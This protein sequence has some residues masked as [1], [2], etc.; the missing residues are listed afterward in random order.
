MKTKRHLKILE[1]VR[2]Y[3]VETQDALAEL[4]IEE[5]YEVTQ[6]TISRDIKQLRL[7]KSAT[8]D[9]KYVYAVS[10][11]DDTETSTGKAL[12]ILR[13]TIKKIDVAQNILVVKTYSGMAQAAAAALDSLNYK[14]IVG[15]IAGDDTVMLIFRDNHTANDFM[16]KLMKMS[17]R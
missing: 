3:D 15:S 2:K 16:E 8:Q 4:L 10:D 17:S 14:E 11:N 9:G 5:G 12:G 7:T 13:D 1:L 6:A